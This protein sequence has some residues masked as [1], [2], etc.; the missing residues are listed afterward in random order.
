MEKFLSHL[1]HQAHGDTYSIAATS[2]EESS[3]SRE[4]KR[5]ITRASGEMHGEAEQLI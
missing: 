4:V 1:L 3:E 2:K 5:T